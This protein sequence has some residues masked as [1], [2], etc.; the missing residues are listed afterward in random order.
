MAF[1]TL[2]LGFW[3]HV[4]ECVLLASHDI[5]HITFGDMINNLW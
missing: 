2:F 1:H 4:V 5:E 3:V